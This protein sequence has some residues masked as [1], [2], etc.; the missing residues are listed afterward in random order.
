MKQQPFSI[1]ERVKSFAYAIDG[2][3]VL[4]QE[5]HN[6]R[7]HLCSGIVVILIGLLFRISIIEWLFIVGSTGAVISMEALN[8]A[9]EN[10]ADFIS[11]DH[12]ELIKKIKDLAAA[13]VLVSAVTAFI[14]GSIVFLPKIINLVTTLI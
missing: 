11:P 1:K 14:I 9:V 12:H 10:I 5:E 2:L 13:A 6:A 4:L 3:K 7:I 8:S